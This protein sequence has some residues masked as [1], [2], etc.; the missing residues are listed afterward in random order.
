[1]IRNVKGEDW[2]VTIAGAP[3]T[4]DD[5]TV[6]SKTGATVDP[7]TGQAKGG[8]LDVGKSSTELAV[9]QRNQS[10][11]KNPTVINAGVTN[12]T[13]VESTQLRREVPA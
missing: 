10:K 8:G 4:P 5:A 12:N 3:P 1:M 2:H 6:T 11:P 13:V 9:E 7:A